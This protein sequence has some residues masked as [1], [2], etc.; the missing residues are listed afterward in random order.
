MVSERAPQ[1]ECER[2][3]I[4]APSSSSERRAGEESSPRH[5][6]IACAGVRHTATAIWPAHGRFTPNLTN[7]PRR[8]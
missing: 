6:I 2:R 3:D 8:F 4:A 7:R 1:E 5:W